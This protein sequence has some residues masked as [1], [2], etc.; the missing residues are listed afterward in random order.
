M[1]AL[2]ASS[3][4]VAVA[5]LS[6]G[7]G[8]GHDRSASRPALRWTGTPQVFT[9]KALPRDRV[10]VGAVRNTSGRTLKLDAAALVVLDADG[11]R[12]RSTGQFA[13]GYAH[14]L[15]GA[16][17]QPDPLPPGELE[18]LGRIVTIPAGGT[19]PLAVSWTVA[20]GHDAGRRSSVDYGSGR[21][22]LP[23]RVRL[24]TGL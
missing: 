2:G 12:L 8:S 17:Q 20:D 5:L 11:R 9:T 14:G 6:A 24:G 1:R 7:C 10:V 23:T 16:F 3:A 19:A 13:A 21:L 22:P 15:Y 4:A 18:R